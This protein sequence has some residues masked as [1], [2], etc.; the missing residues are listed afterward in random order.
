[1]K[2]NK[3]MAKLRLE[4][5]GGQWY[6]INKTSGK[7]LASTTKETQKALRYIALTGGSQFTLEVV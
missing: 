2:G 6:L 4:K 1:M 5:V 3:K 7:I